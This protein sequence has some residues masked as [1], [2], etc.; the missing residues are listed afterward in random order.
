VVPLVS[1]LELLPMPE[2][3]FDPL[4]ID[5][6]LLPLVVVEEDGVDMLLDVD[7]VAAGVV[8]G[9]V[10]DCLAQA[11]KSIAAASAL[12]ATLIFIDNTPVECA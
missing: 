4:D 11:V 2:E 6:E 7:G 3:D 9:W 1:P 10:D 5:E 12:S 8:V